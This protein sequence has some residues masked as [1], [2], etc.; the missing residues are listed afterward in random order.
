MEQ[1]L[2]SALPARTAWNVLGICALFWLLSALG[3][4]QLPASVPPALMFF[5]LYLNALAALVSTVAAAAASAALFLHRRGAR[6]PEPRESG[7]GSALDQAEEIRLD[8]LLEEPEAAPAA[9][10]A[11][12]AARTAHSPEPGRQPGKK[13]RKR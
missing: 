12:A 11:A 5:W 3:L 7:P 10:P 13:V 1:K 2:R 4:L 6:A 8:Q 9:E